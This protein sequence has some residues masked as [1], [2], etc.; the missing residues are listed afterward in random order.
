MMRDNIKTPCRDCKDRVVG[1][2]SV[3]DRYME[4]KK[5]VEAYN[6]KV[7]AEKKANAAPEE[8]IFRKKKRER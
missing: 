6:A 8:F 5:E 7:Y 4:W 2:H 1:C 3:C